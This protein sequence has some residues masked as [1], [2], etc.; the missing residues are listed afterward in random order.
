MKKIA[1]Y[2]ILAVAGMTLCACNEDYKDWAEPTS[3]VDPGEVFI[4]F[5]PSAVNALDLRGMTA[6]SVV[7][8]NPN[9]DVNFD[10]SEVTYDV[11]IFN[12]DKSESVT[13]AADKM[14]RMRRSELQGAIISLFGNIE[15]AR[16]TKM[17]IL[18]HILYD[19]V[20]TTSKATD[21][22]LTVTPQQQELPPVWFIMG[23]CIGVGT[24]VN[25]AVMGLYTSTVAM[26]VNPLNYDELIF[27]T[28]LCDNA[29]FK[30]ILKPGNR[31]MFIGGE[32]YNDNYTVANAGYYKVIVNTA[33]TTMHVEEMPGEYPVYE[34]MSLSTG[35]DMKLITKSATGINHDW[36]G[37]LNV[38]ADTEVKFVAND[39]TTW[40]CAD[41][42]AGKAAKN[43]AGIP[44]KAGNYKVVFNDI[45]GT[46]RFIEK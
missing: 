9:L 5:T 39:G 4:S 16:Q 11:T 43:G 45:M 15:Q 8:F 25:N 46:F 7:A 2:S 23:N 26:Y 17:D 13:I 37:D 41:F 1:L 3:P 12:A 32:T 18:A 21:V 34:S 38:T 40:G 44:V 29:Q 19:G 42:P 36:H 10:G 35:I 27:P 30:I 20:M 31:E 6:D 28:Y 24:F 14:G 22:P 33:D